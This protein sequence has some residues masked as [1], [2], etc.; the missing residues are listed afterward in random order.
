MASEAETRR[1]IDAQLRKAGWEA[2]TENLRYAKGVRP[3]KGRSLAI[4]EWPI[5]PAKY[6]RTAESNT[7]IGMKDH[8]DYALFLGT[9][10]AAV[11]EAKA[12]DKD[13]SAVIDGQCKEYAAHIRHSDAPY[14][15]SKWGAYSVPFVFATNG[16]AYLEQLDTK[17]GVWFLDLRRPYHLSKPLRGWISPTGMRELLEQD[18]AAGNR[19]LRSTSYD[20]LRD[21]DGLSLYPFQIEA[22]RA[23]EAAILRGQRNILLAMATGTG[24]TR[25]MLGLIYRLLTARRF[26]RILFLVDRNTLGE[27]TEDKFKEVK[28]ESLRTLDEIYT[29]RGVHAKTTLP[30]RI[31]RTSEGSV[32]AE[33]PPPQFIDDDTIRVQIATVQSMVK[34]ILYPEDGAPVP[35]VTDY[36]LVIVDEA[37]R[38]YILDRE[39]GEAELLY[40]DQRDFQSKYRAVISYFDAVHIGLTATPALHT[41]EIFG[42]PVFRYTYR[43]AVVDGYLVDH[44]APHKLTTRLSQDGIH[45]R[46]G[47]TAAI[48]NPATGTIVNGE[49]LADE[50]DFDVDDFNRNVIDENFDRTVLTEI[51]RELHPDTPEIYGKTLIFA[52]NDAH[53]DRIV[54]ILRQLYENQK[55]DNG[56]I[57]KITGYTGDGNPKRIRD[58]VQRFKNEKFPSIAVTVDLLSTGIDVP[59]ITALVFMRRIKS[60]ILFEQMLGRATRLCP[61]LKKDHFEI[62]DPVGVYEALAP[63]S[64][65]KPVA[66]NPQ[67]TFAQLLDGFAVLEDDAR[68]QDQVDQILAKLQRRRRTIDCQALEQFKAITGGKDMEGLIV[69]I[70]DSTPGE[71]REK[72]LACAEALRMLDQ[73]SGS[74]PRRVIISDKPDELLAHTRG[75]GQGEKPEDYLDAFSAFL[76]ENINEIAALRVLCTRPRELTRESLKQLRLTL[77]REGF[78][79]LQLNT[80]IRQ[81]TNQ[82]IAADIISLIRRYA[83]GSALLNHGERIHGAIE[84]LK[85]AHDFSS[86]ELRWISRMEK[87]LMEESVLTVSVFDED[88]RF[89]AEGGFQRIDR[90]FRR[91]L[92]S[93]VAELNDYLYDDGGKIA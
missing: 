18:T 83:I 87:Y 54:H 74:V 36:D 78:T 88:G 67:T 41:T 7:D 24:K 61:K 65:M 19:A 89:R 72:L 26:R 56:A 13:V 29:I 14:V 20:L 49:L 10:L 42:P 63:F 17:S 31:E 69:S 51:A 8:V 32:R 71:A 70:R 82:E 60:R 50:L 11:V 5:N 9:R 80:A 40:R 43:E 75:Y 46:A 53:A 64:D 52:V 27:Q 28:L 25:T 57:Q 79:P 4:A 58:A 21:R 2:D 1:L 86:E 3:V 76:R 44:D 12:D 55:L 59:E 23:A 30:A 91:K 81:M 90:I 47:D 84:K 6:S 39:M 35:G 66:V 48:L 33:T 93:V 77:E 15:I 68:I 85:A 73:Q 34:R 37:H 38:G 45:Y 22:I 62:Y 92:E 16:R